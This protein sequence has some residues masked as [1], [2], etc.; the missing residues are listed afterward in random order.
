MNYIE[1]YWYNHNWWQYFLMPLSWLYLIIIT[2]RRYVLVKFFQKKAP[3]PIIVV[4]NLTVGGV[5]KTPLVVALAKALLAGGVKV[6]IVSRGYRARV[7]TLPHEVSLT[8]DSLMVG[9]EPLLLARNTGCPVVIAKKRN[10]AVQLL[11]QRHDCQVIISDDGL[12]HYAMGRTIEIAVV[13]GM[14]L[15]GNALCLPAGPLRE[16]PKRLSEVDFVVVNGGEASVGTYVMNLQPGAL[17]PVQ[18][19]A[20]ISI[21]A[22][23]QPIAAIAAIG[24]PRRFFK[25]LETLGVAFNAYEFP[26]HHVFVQDDLLVDEKTIIMTEKDAVKCAALATPNMYFLP[27]EAH[28]GEDFWEVLW[29]HEGL[30]SYI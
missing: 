28:L 9:D 11:R 13:D 1:K 14:R 27:V 7:K 17:L 25:T 10:Q 12:Q 6:G 22:L 24:N 15:L 30:R 4:G 3:V 16:R 20:P 23:L 26:D 29:A 19:G 5:G 18:G 8:D 2:I 21:S